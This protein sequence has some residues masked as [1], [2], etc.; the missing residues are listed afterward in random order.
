MLNGT[1]VPAVEMTAMRAAW[2]DLAIRWELTWR[3]RR[4]LLPAGG[5]DRPDPPVDTERRMRILIEVGNRIRIDDEKL[6][7]W[8]RTPS[9]LWNWFSPLEVLSG[10]LPELRRF[11][12]FVELGLGA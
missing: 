11:R 10:S 9:E 2:R 7:D 12:V 3:E 1:D 6:R 5:E 8:L 4:A